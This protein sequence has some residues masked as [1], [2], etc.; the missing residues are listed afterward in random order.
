MK[1]ILKST[2]IFYPLKKN[3]L[4]FWILLSLIQGS[5]S[6]SLYA[7]DKK[8]KIALV[9]SGGGAKGIAHIPVLQALDSLGIVPDM[10]IGTSMGSIVGGL[11]AM[12]YTGD[13]IAKITKS[14]KWDELLGGTVSLNNVSVEEMGEF[15]KYLIDIDVKNHK[16]VLK[17]SLINDQNLRE[18]LSVITYPVFKINNF[19]KLPIPYRAVATDIV[20]GKLV[21]LDEGSLGLAMRASMSIPGVFKPIPYKKTLLVD[22]GLLNNF[23][24]D[25]AKSMGAD[26][27][28]GSDVGDEK[29]TIEQLENLSTLIFHTSMLISNLKNESNKKLCDILFSHY[30]N[31]TYSTADFYASNTIYEEGKIAT[32]Q[33]L[34]ALVA[35]AKKLEFY[36]PKKITLP[37]I[38][39]KFVLDSII[40]NNFSAPN[41]DLV[42]K[43]SNLKNGEKYTITDIANGVRKAIGTNLFNQI[44]YNTFSKDDKTILEMNA[45]EYYRNQIKASLHFDTF[46]GFGAIINYTGRN[47]LGK[48]SRILVTGDIAQQPRVR[49]QYQKIFGEEKDWWWRSEAYAHRLSQNVF[50]DAKIV[51][52]IEFSSI[53][54]EN[55]INK[56]INSL[57]SYFGFG[58]NYQYTHLRPKTDPGFNT[59]FTLRS[60]YLNVFEVNLHYSTNNLNKQYFA[61]NGNKLYVEVSRSFHQDID[62][63]FANNNSQS[64]SETLTP[65][66]K[67]NFN[68]ENRIPLN[69]KNVVIMEANAGFMFEDTKKSNQKSSTEYGFASKYFLGGYSANTLKNSTTFAGLQENELN[70]SQFIKASVSL[71]TNLA[72]K[73]FL[74]PH[75]DL[76]SVGFRDFNEFRKDFFAPKGKW[77]KQ[78]ETSLLF[79]TGATISYNT[80]L[81]PVTFDATWVK[82]K[83]L[84]LFFSIGLLFNP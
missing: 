27:I 36:A 57:K 22:G 67:F 52:N 1:A 40:Y 63:N 44:D 75:V 43:R 42:I 56:N 73:L 29:V 68:Y 82:N 30:P 6:Y 47:L 41:L 39:P 10:I 49:V 2:H 21:L 76:A 53:Q 54:F 12:G 59:V 79:S 24:T 20:N 66:T 14:T 83:S 51:D 71:Q 8:P 80:F 23:P 38:D 34:P 77:Q 55:Q 50:F 70:A 81:G 60:Y 5:T 62:V 61:T 4:C 25:I 48:S 3:R 64:F 32:K 7:Q 72:S 16:P 35:L 37:K 11:Y 78:E 18:F 9:L 74:I 31:L 45:S 69:Q 13:S 58:I 19:D 26:F 17:S 65:Y 15:N 84:R 33:N 28:I 46:R